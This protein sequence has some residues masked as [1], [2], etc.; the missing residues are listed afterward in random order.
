MR[1]LLRLLILLLAT[2]QTGFTRRGV[3]AAETLQPDDS[4]D[5]LRASLDKVFSDPQ[6]SQAQLGIE[7]FSLDRS[8]TLYEMQAQRLLIP[9][10][11]NK[12]IT[13]AV[14]LTRLSP[15]YRFETRLL[16]DG[17]VENGTL[18]GN[19]VIVG[20]GDP[21]ASAN[22]Q[23]GDPFAI[24]RNWAAEL[25]EKKIRKISGDILGDAGAFGEPGLGLG[26]E[27][28]DLSQVYAAP[29]SALQFNDN[30]LALEIT[31]GAEKGDPA[32]IRTSPLEN[33]LKIN[34]RITTVSGAGPAAIQIEYGDSNE[35]IDASGTIPL[36]SAVVSR[37]VAVRNPA[38]YYLSALKRVLSE[39]GITGSLGIK[40]AD[41]YRSPVLSP[42]WIHASPELSEIIKPLLKK[43]LNLEAETLVRALGWYYR[44]E[45]TFAKG[46]EV[47]EETLGQMGIEIGRYS[48]AD[49][50]GLSRLNLDSADEFVR[51]LQFMYRDRNFQQFFNALPIAGTDGT[52]SE[53]MKGTKAENNVHAKTGTMTNVSS[54]SGY[55]KTADG[56]MLAFSILANNFIGS[57]QPVE[58]MQDKA[59]DI[60]AGFSRKKG[61]S[62]TI[63]EFSRMKFLRGESE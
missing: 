57:K 36:K 13:A 53:R 8:E 41:L 52:L 61:T 19:L 54:I 42:L 24:F 44:G 49:G 26:W 12:L 59:L 38:L 60:L 55:L 11:C 20:S 3:P 5:L 40:V 21:S 2:W 48:F 16:A 35:T 43:S 58:S 32:F 46:K 15:A 37:T 62:A 51:I 63:L 9:A 7:V 34:N 22:F 14:A 47:V 1:Y 28:N 6:F 10:S 17:Q 29:V 4:L 31:P 23:A 50:S 39:E 25:K 33:Y 56:E 45:G 18:K 30:A 27:W